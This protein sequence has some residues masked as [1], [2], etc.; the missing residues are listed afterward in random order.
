M[1]ETGLNSNHFSLLLDLVLSVLKIKAARSS[2]LAVS[3]YKS[4][5]LQN[6]KPAVIFLNVFLI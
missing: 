6:H 3:L 4:S 5:K 1:I 2:E